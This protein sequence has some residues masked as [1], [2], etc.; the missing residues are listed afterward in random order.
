MRYSLLKPL[1][2]TAAGLCLCLSSLHAQPA[3]ASASPTDL[4]RALHLYEGKWAGSIDLTSYHGKLLTTMQV[5]KEY[6]I[7][8]EAG[9]PVLLGR[10]VYGQQGT[11]HRSQ[12]RTTIEGHQL[13]NQITQ[14]GAQTH[15]AGIIEGDRITWREEGKPES[16]TA[17][18]QDRFMERG[19]ERLLVTQS[20]N[21]IREEQGE[22]LTVF[23]SGRFLYKGPPGTSPIQTW[24]D[25]PLEGIPLVGN[26]A[27]SPSTDA[28]R[29]AELSQTLKEAQTQLQAA[30]QRIELLEKENQ[31]LREKAAQPAREP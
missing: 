18:Y 13:L 7:T 4:E 12:S 20:R 3:P 16:E 29:L 30:Q 6:R 11:R 9:Q 24:F 15:Y 22:S 26:P 10:F 21:V 5:E 19:G 31:K 1:T 25:A 8:R 2:H 14:G 17:G 23:T 28:S 27:A